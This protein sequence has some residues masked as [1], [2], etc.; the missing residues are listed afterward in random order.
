MLVWSDSDGTERTT[1]HLLLYECVR[2]VHHLCCALSSLACIVLEP[3]AWQPF[4]KMPH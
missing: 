2:P 1:N 3:H 4:R